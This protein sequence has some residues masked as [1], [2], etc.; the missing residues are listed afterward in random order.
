[1]RQLRKGVIQMV[2][3]PKQAR[4]VKGLRQEDV[5]KKIGV[6][7]Q[8]YR[9]LENNPEDFTISQAKTFSELVGIPYD[10]IFFS[11]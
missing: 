11:Q 7:I 2:F 4:L 1:M 3:S 9:K 10:Q 8:T 6:Y 5:A